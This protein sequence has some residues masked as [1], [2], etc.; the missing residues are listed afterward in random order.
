MVKP[1]L[2]FKAFSVSRSLG[3]IDLWSSHQATET[4]TTTVSHSK[5]RIV[6]RNMGKWHEVK[7]QVVEPE[8]LV[9]AQ[10][11]AFSL[12]GRLWDGVCELA[13]QIV[14]DAARG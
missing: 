8:V 3:V 12:A 2:F 6:K 14:L 10:R 5:S 7:A 1:E 4:P 11:E 13:V 9:L